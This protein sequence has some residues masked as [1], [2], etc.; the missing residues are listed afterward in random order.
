MLE[1]IEK[2]WKTIVDIFLVMTGFSAIAIYLF[3]EKKKIKEAAA[4]IVLQ[5]DE[6]RNRMIEM[7]RYIDNGVDYGAFYE[8]LPL[9]DINYWSQ[10][11]HYFV[12]KMDY[13]SFSRINKFYQ[14]V[15]CIQKQQ[16]LIQ[17]LQ[18]NEFLQKANNSE[19]ENELILGQVVRTLNGVFK[20]YSILEVTGTGGYRKLRKL[21]KIN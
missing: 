19:S 1:V 11:K 12:R 18:K 15:E 7:Q 9:I 6:I 10:Y 21:S 20:K 4:L 17:E 3:Q 16:N 5:I 2:N 13:T 8:S 14:Y